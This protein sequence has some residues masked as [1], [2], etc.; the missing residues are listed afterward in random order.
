[1]QCDDD[2]ENEDKTKKQ[3]IKKFSNR[4]IDLDQ[5]LPNLFCIFK[6]LGLSGK[7]TIWF[8][9][10]EIWVRYPDREPFKC[11]DLIDCDFETEEERDDFYEE[12]ITAWGSLYVSQVV[13]LA[14][15]EALGTIKEVLYR[16]LD[17]DLH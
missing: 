10:K 15:G 7:P 8:S 11:R 4:T 14:A 2:P 17:I 13:P 1:M 12:I 6:A 9:C 16:K 3:N 5:I